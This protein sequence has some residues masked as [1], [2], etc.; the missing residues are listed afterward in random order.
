MGNVAQMIVDSIFQEVWR[1]SEFL[2]FCS[3]AIKFMQEVQ[4]RMVLVVNFFV[5]LKFISFAKILDLVYN[6]EAI[7]AYP[8]LINC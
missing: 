6:V 2:N 4:H 8:L 5:V 1:D 3:C 7:H